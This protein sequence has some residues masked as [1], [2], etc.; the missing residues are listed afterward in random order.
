MLDSSTLKYK[1]FADLR[2]QT[3]DDFDGGFSGE[4]HE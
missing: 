2:Y 1:G 4:Q 3:E